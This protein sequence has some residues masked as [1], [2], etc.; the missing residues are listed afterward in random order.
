MMNRF[1][2]PL[3]L[4][5]TP[6][7][8]QAAE[9][10]ILIRMVVVT[11]FEIG[12]DTGDK[13]GEFQHW[14][15]QI[16]TTLPFPGGERPLR[17][18]AKRGLLVLSTGMGTNRA[19]T[20]TMLLGLD[21]RFDL[22]KAYWLVA[23]IAGVNPNEASIGS[24]A[25]IGDIIDTDLGFEIDAREI[26]ADWPTGRVPWERAKPYQLPVPTDMSYNLFPLNK[27][28][29]DWA[30]SLTKDVPIPDTPTLQKMRA[31]FI[32]YPK[33]LE[34]PKVTTGEEASGQ[35][36][37]HGKLLNSFTEVH[38][39]LSVLAKS[40]KADPNRLLVLRTGSNYATQAPGQSAADS[41]H[42]ENAELSGLESSV[43]A[44]YRIGR[45][46]VDE[47]TGNWAKYA[48]TIPGAK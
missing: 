15:E 42:N 27:P 37:W 8:V 6:A 44:A 47:I 48:D 45:P 33:A 2:L 29:R 28:L 10:P 16:P 14:A 39:A 4:L 22:S 32:G 43:D 12:A 21:P 40:G 17:Y 24:A 20:S 30:Y 34:Q 31:R 5:A 3:A 26:P 38:R 18:D 36:F 35:T 1:L 23:A 19:A 11:A 7:I 25:W 41:L 9:R 46:V 13:A